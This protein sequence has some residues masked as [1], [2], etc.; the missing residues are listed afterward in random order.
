MW[1][2]W[3][4]AWKWMESHENTEKSVLRKERNQSQ[5]YNYK[6]QNNKLTN[7]YESNLDEGNTCSHCPPPWRIVLS[8]TSMLYRVL[9]S[10]LQ[11]NDYGRRLLRS[12][13][14][15][16]QQ[17]QEIKMKEISDLH[18]TIGRQHNHSVVL[19]V[20]S[21]PFGGVEWLNDTFTR[22]I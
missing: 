4:E 3:R 10:V 9:N 22:I 14:V 19:S 15:S 6:F 17:Q 8:F 13:K 16:G 5:C 7:Y 11:E 2:T 21:N 1:E 12:F 18:V 20:R